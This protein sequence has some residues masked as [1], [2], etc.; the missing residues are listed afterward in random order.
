[1]WDECIAGDFLLN[2]VKF[3]EDEHG[4]THF[5]ARVIHQFCRGTLVFPTLDDANQYYR[6]KRG[7]GGTVYYMKPNIG[8]LESTGVFGGQGSHCP[9][10]AGNH[11]FFTFAKPASQEGDRAANDAKIY[12]TLLDLVRQRNAKKC[13]L[14]IVAQKK[15][16][17]L[18][19]KTEQEQQDL[20]QELGEL[21]KK[22]KGN[23]GAGA[24]DPRYEG[25]GGGKRAR[26]Y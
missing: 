24:G 18:Y 1:L 3:I 2:H 19:K 23:H 16:E 10:M 26:T 12:T 4:N 15:N 20:Q 14:D 5:A 7:G 13:T 6:Q 22:R 21:N 9:R 11:Q 25:G 8:R 17:P